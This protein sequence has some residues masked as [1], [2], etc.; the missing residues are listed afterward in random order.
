MVESLGFPYP[1]AFALLSTAAELVAPLLIGLGIWTRSAAAIL[2][3]NM[4]VAV[5]AEISGND[6]FELAAMYLLVA[7]ALVVMGG[8]RLTVGR[9]FSSR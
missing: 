3:V 5:W 9:L 2:A 4:S 1:L 6:S 8:G 7:L